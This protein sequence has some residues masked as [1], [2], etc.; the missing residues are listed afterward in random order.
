MCHDD[1]TVVQIRIK[2]AGVD[3]VTFFLYFS[4]KSIPKLAMKEN[5]EQNNSNASTNI[6]GNKNYPHLATHLFFPVVSGY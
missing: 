4:S 6:I 2:S 5:R 3:W 1:E